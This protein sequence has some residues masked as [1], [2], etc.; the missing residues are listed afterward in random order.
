MASREIEGDFYTTVPPIPSIALSTIN[1]TVSDVIPV[2]VGATFCKVAGKFT[3]ASPD[4]DADGAYTIAKRMI[5]ETDFSSLDNSSTHRTGQG[6]ATSRGMLSNIDC[7]GAEELKV[8]QVEN[9]N[10]AGAITVVSLPFRFVF[11]P[12]AHQ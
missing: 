3:S 1:T 9:T 6:A 5:G 2:P 8:L 12:E 11:P 4:E 10:G 7:D